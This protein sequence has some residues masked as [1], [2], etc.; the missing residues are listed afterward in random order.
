MKLTRRDD[1]DITGTSLKYN[2]FDGSGNPAFKHEATVST[3]YTEITSL[4]NWHKFW[5]TTGMDYK[6]FRKQIKADYEGDWATLTDAEKKTLIEHNLWL[7]SET[8]ANLNAL[9][10]SQERDDFKEVVLETLGVGDDIYSYDTTTQTITAANTHQDLDFSNNKDISSWDHV[11]GT[12]IFTCQKTGTYFCVVE[13][14]MQKT[15]AGAKTGN[16]IALFDGAEIVGSHSGIDLITNDELSMYS[17]T[18]QFDGIKGKDLKVQIAGSATNVQ[19]SAGPNPGSASVA[20]SA[21]I[22]ILHTG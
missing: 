3:G 21:T 18:F 14:Y 11:E 1:V 8:E 2:K 16:M 12:A 7:S 19:V 5:W 10:T 20:T 22:N 15:S 6:D 4:A 9:Y 13:V 17:S